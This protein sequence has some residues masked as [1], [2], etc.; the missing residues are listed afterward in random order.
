M[1]IIYPIKLR[2]YFKGKGKARKTGSGPELCKLSLIFLQLNL[3]THKKTE[4]PRIRQP[5]YDGTDNPAIS[6]KSAIYS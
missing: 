1:N 4:Q 3:L 6:V 2:K 5:G